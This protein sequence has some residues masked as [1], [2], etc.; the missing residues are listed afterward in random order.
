MDICF[1]GFTISPYSPCP[2]R[3]AK[4]LRSDDTP[5][6]ES[7]CHLAVARCEQ[8]VGNAPAEAEAL[9]AAA[10][11][12]LQAEQKVQYVRCPTFEE[13]LMAGSTDYCCKIGILQLLR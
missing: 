11:T 5:Q 12:F 1:V 2:G 7:L 9:V 10:R 3:L 6:Y 8:S 13:H 4:R